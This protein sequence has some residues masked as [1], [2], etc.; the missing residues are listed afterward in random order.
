MQSPSGAVQVRVSPG[1]TRPKTSSRFSKSGLSLL[2]VARRRYTG[3]LPRL[4]TVTVRSKA[5]PGA[6][7]F[8]GAR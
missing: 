2:V 1:F 8:S 3:A 4:V 6:A 5:S 7:V